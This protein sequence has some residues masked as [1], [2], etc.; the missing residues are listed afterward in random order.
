MNKKLFYTLSLT[1]GP[2]M[3]FIGGIA[4]LILIVC[5]KRP[6]IYGGCLCFTIGKNWGG[7]SF[8]LVMIVCHDSTDATKNHELGHAL[9][10]AV[11]GVLMPF[12][13]SIPSAIRYWYRR[14]QDCSTLPP[15]DSIWFERQATEWGNI[16]HNL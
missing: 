1:W 13:V 16:Y 15:Y 14:F 5:N 7:V 9:Q 3:T 2:I 6:T 4:C 11:Y 8:G 12:I 10:N